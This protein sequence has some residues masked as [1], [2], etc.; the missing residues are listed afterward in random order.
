ML[1]L[2]NPHNPY[3]SHSIKNEY[4]NPHKPDTSNITYF[5]NVLMFQCG[6]SGLNPHRTHLKS[7]SFTSPCA[8]TFSQG[9]LHDIKHG[10]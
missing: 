3:S 9:N 7:H 10:R 5:V 6:Q 4:I 8:L 1:K 2:R